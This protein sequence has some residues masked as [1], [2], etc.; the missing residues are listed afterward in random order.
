LENSTV[1]DNKINDQLIGKTVYDSYLSLWRQHIFGLFT[2]GIVMSNSVIALPIIMSTEIHRHNANMY[3]KKI[4]NTT[5]NGNIAPS[6]SSSESW[7]NKNHQWW[8]GDS[9]ML[10]D[11]LS[12]LLSKSMIVIKNDS[13]ILPIENCGGVWDQALSDMVL[14]KITNTYQRKEYMYKIKTSR[15]PGIEYFD[16]RYIDNYTWDNLH[17]GDG[18]VKVIKKSFDYRDDKLYTHGSKMFIENN[19]DLYY[20]MSVLARYDW[21]LS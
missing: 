14:H 4:L 3:R 13:K 2:P 18:N 19:S 5:N 20:D 1:I 10:S 11:E 9:V 21:G 12:K 6:D 17:S 16:P 15:Q 7:G 8:I